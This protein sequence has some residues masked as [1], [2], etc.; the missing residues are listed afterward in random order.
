[1]GIFELLPRLIRILRHVD[2]TANFIVNSKQ[3]LVLTIDAPDFCFRV[4]EKVKKLNSTYPLQKAHLIAPSVWC[5][6]EYRA[7]KIATLYNVLFCILPFEPPYFEKYGLKTIFIGY[8]LLGTKPEIELKNKEHNIFTHRR[9]FFILTPGSR[10]FEIKILLPIMLEVVRVVRK[11]Y[12][13]DCYIFTTSDT[14]VWVN[15]YLQNGYYPGVFS[16][17]EELHQQEITKNAI[18]ALAKSGTNTMELAIAAVPMVVI[19][20]FS[21][22]TNLLIRIGKFFWRKNFYANLINILAKEEIIPELLLE[23]CKV[24]TIVEKV[25]YLLDHEDIRSEQVEKSK[26]ILKMLNPKDSISAFNL[27]SQKLQDLVN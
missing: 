23:N 2:E 18:L 7:R 11:K 8:P 14:H 12:N 25:S 13:F 4:M 3:D 15:N 19:Y 16:T 5:Y 21:F 10:K 6:R 9:K 20:R 24:S 22:M 1:M 26:K 27:V 17:Q